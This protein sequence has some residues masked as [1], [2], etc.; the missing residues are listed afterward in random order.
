MTDESGHVAPPAVELS[1]SPQSDFRALRDWIS[2]I[3]DVDVTQTPGR[4]DRGR[5]GVWD[6]LTVLA[7][8]SGALSVAIASLPAFIRSRRSDLTI[9]VRAGDKEFTLK[10][11][12]TDQ[13]KEIVDGILHG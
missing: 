10:A 7:G 8:S 6:V 4:P 3:P 12:N 5:L 9:T 1:V 2:R 11:A 13:A